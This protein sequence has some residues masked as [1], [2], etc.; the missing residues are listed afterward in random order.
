VQ[1]M[2]LAKPA[3]ELIEAGCSFGYYGMRLQDC[4]EKRTFSEVRIDPLL[5]IGAKPN[6]VEAN[7]LV[8]RINLWI[9]VDG[10][11][12]VLVYVMW[13]LV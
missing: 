12:S 7:R 3:S 6:A 10:V 5:E 1:G 8:K 4:V 9:I 13:R 2:Y 11:L